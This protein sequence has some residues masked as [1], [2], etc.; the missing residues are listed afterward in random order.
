MTREIKVIFD[1]C[2]SHLMMES[3]RP[4]IERDGQ[5]LILKAV[6]EYQKA[7]VPDKEWIPKI[8]AEGGW[9][10]ISADLGRQN[11]R[12]K[13]DEKLPYLCRLHGVTHVL[14]SP[15]VH[16][17]S[18]F[19]KGQAIIAVWRKIA[20]TAKAPAG[21]RFSLRQNHTKNGFLLVNAD[22]EAKKREKDSR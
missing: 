10:V 7:G 17:L 14:L 12:E 13:R 3:L 5:T 21:T 15:G 1:E 4:F 2:L 22:D 20:K 16:A 8:A 18:D 6:I 11:K 9:I 19:E